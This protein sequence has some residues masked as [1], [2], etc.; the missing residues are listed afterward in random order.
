M[1]IQDPYDGITHS[2]SPAFSNRSFTLFSLGAAADLASADAC[3]YECAIPTIPHGTSS[4]KENCHWWQKR[5]SDW[6]GEIYWAGIH[7]EDTMIILFP[8]ASKRWRG[9]V[10]PNP[11]ML[12]NL[13]ESTKWTKIC[14]THWWSTP[15]KAV[16][17]YWGYCLFPNG[18]ASP[19]FGRFLLNAAWLGRDVK[20]YQRTSTS[21]GPWTPWNQSLS[22]VGTV[23]FPTLVT[24]GLWIFQITGNKYLNQLCTPLLDLRPL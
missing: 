15:L 2:V 1:R 9:F 23:P 6:S 13:S 21:W 4:W 11:L 18:V 14:S 7:G 3:I 22:S 17:L 16:L 19:A 12:P 10:T 5:S 24:V 20:K 8:A